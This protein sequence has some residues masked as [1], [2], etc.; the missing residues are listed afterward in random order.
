MIS[1]YAS[2]GLLIYACTVAALLGAVMGSFLNC[3]AGRLAKGESFLRGRSRCPACGHALAAA[4]LVPVSSWVLLRGKCRYCGAK[5]SV[6][7]LLAELIFAGLT[8]WCLLR[9]DL[10][11]L[12]LRNWVLLCCLFCLSLVDL[13]VKLIPNGTLLI[14]AGAWAAAEPFLSAGWVSTLAHLG[15][16]VA[17]SGGILLLSLV[18]DKVLGR[19][20]LGGGDVKLFAVTGL[21]L[22][23]L[24]SLFALILSCVF[25]LAFNLRSLRGKGEGFP[26]GPWIALGTVIL[27]F[28]GEGLV[29]WYLGLMG[30][31]HTPVF[32]V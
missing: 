20:S 6:R 32:L 28:C 27:L 8:V 4:D 22:G 21:Y 11:V 19:E 30:L 17:L 1:V 3:A 10:T 23:L 18:M 12:G 15:T 13:E 2:T 29:G 31:S 25:G 9:F 14:A 26:Y 24:P 5:V 16:A 7:Y